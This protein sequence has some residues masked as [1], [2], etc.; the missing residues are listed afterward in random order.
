MSLRAKDIFSFFQLKNHFFMNDKKLLSNIISNIKTAHSLADN[1]DKMRLL[2]LVSS[3]L[4]YNELT[5][6]YLFE[7]SKESYTNSRNHF[8]KNG[9]GA[10]VKKGGRKPTSEQNKKLIEDFLLDDSYSYS[11]GGS[12]TVITRK[13]EAVAIIRYQSFP[14]TVLYE[15][16][17]KKFPQNKVSLSTFKKY[18]PIWLKSPRNKSDYCPHCYN[19]HKLK[20]LVEIHQNC[21]PNICFESRIEECVTTAQRQN[22]FLFHNDRVCKQR[23]LFKEM[24]DNVQRGEV[25]IVIDFK[26]NIS[27]NKTRIST[28]HNFYN[29][30]QRTCFGAVLIYRNNEGKVANHYFDIFSSCLSHQSWFVLEIIKTK[31]MPK[32]NQAS[33]QEVNKITFWMDNAKHFRSKAMFGGLVKLSQET[34]IIINWCFFGEYHGKSVC[35]SRFSVISRSMK[36]YV[37]SKK[38]DRTIETME[39]VFKAIKEYEIKSKTNTSSDQIEIVPVIPNSQEIIEIENLTIYSIYQYNPNQDKLDILVNHQEPFI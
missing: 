34:K 21:I 27:L 29:K 11:A 28:N 17:I 15:A 18:K 35:D 6:N 16:F 13:G 1:R 38:G 5:K 14:M 33:S 10:P 37:N 8:E 7:I 19:G 32:I 9:A 2:S 25:I 31:I 4:T 30:P 20:I 36:E 12:N 39:D 24:K 26:E 22:A 3:H 23:N